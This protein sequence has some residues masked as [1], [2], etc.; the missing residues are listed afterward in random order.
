[1]SRGLETKEEKQNKGASREGSPSACSSF[2]SG[3][4]GFALKQTEVEHSIT[5]FY[6]LVIPVISRNDLLLLL[7][8]K[9]LFFYIIAFVLFRWF[10]TLFYQG[11]F[12]S[13]QFISASTLRPS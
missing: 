13:V 3:L 12:L 6:A 4:S 5:Q 2:P 8:K 11:L 7:L 10:L 1:M 9:L